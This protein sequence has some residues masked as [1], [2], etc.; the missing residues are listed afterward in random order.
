MIGFC[1]RVR[2]AG[3]RE[4][5]W[6]TDTGFAVDTDSDTDSDMLELPLW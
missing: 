6:E 4:P 1:S 3:R 2:G 5:C